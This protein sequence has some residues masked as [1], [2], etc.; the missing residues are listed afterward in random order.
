MK[1]ILKILLVLLLVSCESELEITAP[2]E[3]DTTGLCSA[4]E[5]AIAA[6]SGLDGAFRGS[7]T[8][9]WRLG[10]IRSDMW[11]GQAFEA[12][13]NLPLIESNITVSTAP[14][15]GWAGFYGKIHHLNDFIANA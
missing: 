10:E 5:G 14:F 2:S 11:G 12:P 15:G 8:N 7:M 6:H 4:E 3:L 13:A 9:C 1:N